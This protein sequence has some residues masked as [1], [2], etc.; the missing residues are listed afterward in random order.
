VKPPQ[1]YLTEDDELALIG[2][3]APALMRLLDRRI[4]GALRLIQADY[5]AGKSDLRPATAAYVAYVELKR[6]LINKL[7]QRDSQKGQ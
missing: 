7:E 6:D 1:N 4:D 5:H 2:V 3:A